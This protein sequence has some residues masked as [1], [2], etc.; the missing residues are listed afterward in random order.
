MVFAFLVLLVGVNLVE[1][2]AIRKVS[3][4]DLGPATEIVDGDQVNLGEL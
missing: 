3:L 4:L 2:A 1:N